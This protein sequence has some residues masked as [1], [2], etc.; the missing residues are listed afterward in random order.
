MSDKE[1]ILN[2]YRHSKGLS[3]AAEKLARNAGVL[4]CPICQ[5]MHVLGTPHPN[6]ETPEGV[7]VEHRT[8]KRT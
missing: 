5:R 7:V 3:Q 8:L 1:D 2:I 6:R 4:K